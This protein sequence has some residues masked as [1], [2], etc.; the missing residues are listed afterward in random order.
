[1]AYITI[2]QRNFEHNLNLLATKAGGIEKMMVVL[3]D[4]A[5][6]HGLKLMAELSQKLGAKR[7]AVKNFTEACSIAHLFDEVLVLVDRP[8]DSSYADNISLAINSLEALQEVQKSCSIHL[9]LDTGMH[10][11]GLQISEYEEA[12]NIIKKNS[13]KLKG[14]FTHFRSS[15]V[16][17]SEY[18]WQENNYQKSKEF[19]KTLIKKYSLPMPAFH[20]CNSAALLRR[21]EEFSDDY[22][23]CGIALYGYTDLPKE[24]ESF[25]LKPVMSLWAQRLS[26]RVLKK[27]KR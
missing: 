24:Y 9:N 5:Y 3:K 16:L 18:F 8:I 11:N 2:N 20:S 15:D 4:N 26:S 25:D 23:R 7:A 12:L 27:Q 10:R 19:F 21:K 14:V 1:M 6:G 17:D 22:A 13:L